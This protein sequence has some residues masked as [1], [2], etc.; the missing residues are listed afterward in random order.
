M[1]YCYSINYIQRYLFRIVLVA[2]I[3][4]VSPGKLISGVP[5]WAKTAIWYQ[6]FP[7]RFRNGDPSNDPKVPDLTDSWPHDTITNWSI[8]P[9]NSDW[10]KLQPWEMNGKGF[11]YNAQLRRYGGD[12]QG[13]IDKLDYLQDLGITAIYLN[14][15][16][17][18]PSLHKYDATFYHHVDNNFGPDPA[19]DVRIWSKEDPSNPATWKWTTA[20]SLFLRLIQESHKKGM[21]VII[22]GV[23]NH[24]GMTFWAFKDVEKDGERSRFRDWFTIYKYDDPSTPENEF[25]YQG[26]YDVKELPEL[27]EGPNGFSEPIR[28]HIHAIVKRWMDPNG[29]GNPSDGIDGWRLDV[30][31]MVSLSFW[32]TFRKWTR[33][34]NPQSYTVGEVWWDDWEK[35]RMFDPAPWIQ[36]GDVFDAVM[37]YRL[38]VPILHYF[39]DKKNRISSSSFADTLRK[40]YDEFLQDVNQV[41]MNTLDSHDTDRLPSIIVNP[42]R[43]FDHQASVADNKSYDVRRPNDEERRIQKL[44]LLFQFTTIGAPSIYYGDEAGMWGGDDPDQRKPMIWDDLTYE[45]EQSHP[46]NKVR[47]A[48]EVFFDKDLLI[49]HQRLVSMRRSNPSLTYGTLKFI[50]TDDENNIVVYTRE[51][52]DEH[53]IVC[54]NNSDQPQRVFLSQHLV[55]NSMVVNDVLTGK[56]IKSQKSLFEIVLEPQSGSV[57]EKSESKKSRE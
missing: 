13:I 4:F 38:T 56:R 51:Y 42:D 45:A 44:V 9:W 32:K 3:V 19:R 8:S 37:N 18:S 21:H 17:E 25:S 5:E 33:E 53:I 12:I 49:Y 54:I 52:N 24:V 34:I 7:E 47:P 10:Y 46:L 1:P 6:I 26:W 30:A 11:Y 2:G 28:E 40:I 31:N 16:F 15:I 35:N 57:L 36:H 48:D 55:G 43:S 27:K 29:D 39:T 23:F 41:Q 22:D 14:P 50:Q 20:D